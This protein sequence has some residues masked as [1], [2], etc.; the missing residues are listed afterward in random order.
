MD[1]KS[2]VTE[3]F[4]SYAKI[5]TP[6]CE[7]SGA[8]PSSECQF[9]F[10]KKLLSE[11]KDLGISDASLDE[12][13]YVYGSLPAT[14]GC[15]NAPSVG[16]IS[17]M[18]TVSDFANHNV[19]PIVHE[20][21]DGNDFEIGESGRFLR[22][23]D[24]SHLKSLKGRTLITSDGTTVL[25]ADDKAG[26]AEIMTLLQ[27]LTESGTLHGKICVGFTPD[28]EIG[29]GADYFDVERFGADFAFTSDGGAEGEI[30]YE[31][32][33]AA[34]A[35]FE[36]N[37]FNVHPGSAKD[38]MVNAAFVACEIN[39][40]LPES[41]TPRNTE[42]YE[43]FYHLTEL[44]GNVEKAKAAYIVRDHD[45][46]RFKEKLG[47]L[48]EIENAVNE[49][50]GKGTATLKV[51]EQYKNMSEIIK[52]NFHLIENAR[53]A[54]KKAG[55]NPVTVPIRGGTDGARLSFMGLPCPNLGTG[56][57][58]FHG[59]FEHITAEGM[60]KA[61]EILINITEIYSKKSAEEFK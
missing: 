31:N 11:L 7:T 33:N 49:K 51:K 35:V 22:S 17:H 19:C 24:F 20:N 3:R 21:F 54:S 59:P 5:L 52:E 40:M 53:A 15:E 12:K 23:A 50:Y 56:G 41:E 60:E 38:I 30:E 58:A 48:K 26:V 27:Y 18:D 43:G 1:I 4:L 34:S 25:G 29:E 42:N 46:M 2:V 8:H 16:F 61:V 6:S 37:G 36:I 10:A 55:V 32:F 9:V 57:Y 28:E 13:C 45:E 39:S 47:V 14:A 44:S